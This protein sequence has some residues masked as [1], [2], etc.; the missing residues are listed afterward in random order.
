MFIYMG[1]E[2]IGK[3]FKFFDSIKITIYNINIKI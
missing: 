2:Y 3:K 1:I